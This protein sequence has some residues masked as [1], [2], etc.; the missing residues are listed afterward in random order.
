MHN[1][2]SFVQSNAMLHNI[3]YLFNEHGKELVRVCNVIQCKPI[4]YSS[5]HNVRS[6]VQCNATCNLFNEH[7]KELVLV[8]NAMQK[9]HSLCYSSIHKVRS[10][11]QGNAMLHNICYLFNKHGKR[12]VL[13]CNAMQKV[14]K[15][16]SS[17]HNDR[18]FVQCNATC[19]LLNKHLNICCAMQCKKCINVNLQCT[20]IDRL[21]NAMQC[22]MLSL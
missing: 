9:V 2:R 7:G 17:V 14:H 12:L 16:S 21:C 10:F 5:I 22:N 3:C 4:C 15:C 13:V 19:Y 18:S 8:C 20:T 6:I 11:V 1:V